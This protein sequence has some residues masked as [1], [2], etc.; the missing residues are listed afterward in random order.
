MAEATQIV[1]FGDSVLSSVSV[2]QVVVLSQWACKWLKFGWGI[3][4]SGSTKEQLARRVL[5]QLDTVL[6]EPEQYVEEIVD[7]RTR[8]IST[9][10]KCQETTARATTGTHT[11]G[12]VG[13]NGLVDE[14]TRTSGAALEY[15]TSD[16]REVVSRKVTQRLIK[17][18]RSNFAAAVSK[19]AYNKF[20]ERPMSPANVLVTRKWIQKY[21]EDRFKDLRTCDKNLAIDRALF[22]SFV[23]TKDFLAM[24]LLLE[25]KAAQDRISGKGIFG[26]I[27]RFASSA[28]A[29]TG[30]VE[31]A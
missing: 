12:E 11:R 2:D 22:L 13:V 30:A 19:Q 9:M 8:I 29:P 24:R 20:G 1:E 7:E 16:V 26:K 21:L 23:P 25:T 10:S 3:V 27:F 4:V 17:K 28:P 15:K 14:I 31:L 18:Q 6:G 5:A